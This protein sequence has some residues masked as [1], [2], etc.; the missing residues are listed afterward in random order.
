M[1]NRGRAIAGYAVLA[2]LGFFEGLTGTFQYSRGPAPL[3]SI[4]FALLLL[5][6]CLLASWGT[7]SVGGALAPALGW[8]VAA[9]ALSMP[10]GGGS[11]IIANTEAG[12]FF[13]YGGTLCAAAA[14]STA[15]VLWVSHQRNVG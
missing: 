3:A 9:F 6:T 13:L 8:I 14:V 2:L 4:L 1:L 11:V 10:T 15:F 7:R 5:A 12:K